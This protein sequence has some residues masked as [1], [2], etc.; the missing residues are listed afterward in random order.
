MVRKKLARFLQENQN[1]Q[2]IRLALT[3]NI[4]DEDL[5]D[6]T[7]EKKL[8]HIL[9]KNNLLTQ[10][11]FTCQ[12]TQKSPQSSDRPSQIASLPTTCRTALAIY[13]DWRQ[14]DNQGTKKPIVG[15]NLFHPTSNH[16]G[17][18]L[19]DFCEQ[20]NLVISSTWGRGSCKRENNSSTYR[21]WN[22]DYKLLN[23]DSISKKYEKSVEDKILTA[24]NK[25]G[26][27]PLDWNHL[28]EILG[29]SVREHLKFNKNKSKINRLALAKFMKAKFWKSRSPKD[30]AMIQNFKDARKELL[31]LQEKEDERNANT[32]FNT[33]VQ[34]S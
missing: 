9:K 28:T 3:N 13:E 16:L 24:L 27:N 17:S 19:L 5:P 4:M 8:K 31:D 21:F 26:H 12:N 25:H 23:Q 29:L 30:P 10:E 15:Y 14:D 33:D 34:S 22:W 18:F 20:D 11:L 32:S 1:D 6:Q 2:R 7:L